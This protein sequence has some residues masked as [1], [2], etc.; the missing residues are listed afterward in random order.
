MPSLDNEFLAD[1]IDSDWQLLRQLQSEV[2]AT[3]T[4]LNDARAAV[5]ESNALLR[6]IDSLNGPVIGQR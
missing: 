4:V 6:F 2:T 1:A 3:Q 5:E